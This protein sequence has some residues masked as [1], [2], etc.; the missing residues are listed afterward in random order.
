MAP[1]SSTSAISAV[2]WSGVALEPKDVTI[3]PLLEI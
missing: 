2:S 3:L 1:S